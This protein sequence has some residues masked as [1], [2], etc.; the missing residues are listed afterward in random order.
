MLSNE[1]AT[2]DRQTCLVDERGLVRFAIAAAAGIASSGMTLVGW[3]L[4]GVHGAAVGAVLAGAGAGLIAGTFRGALVA[5]VVGA[6]PAV[7]IDRYMIPTPARELGGFTQAA[8]A[9]GIAFLIVLAL[10]AAAVGVAAARAEHLDLARSARRRI[11]LGVV[12]V[13]VGA[14]WT[15][16]GVVVSRTPV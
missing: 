4:L 7:W 16:F 12:A 11:V 14:A 3:V 2:T 8:A 6:L 15:W 5:V 1:A 10:L 13:G 9:M